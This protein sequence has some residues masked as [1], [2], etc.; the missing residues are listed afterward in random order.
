MLI[1]E[2]KDIP[3]LPYASAM[4]APNNNIFYHDRSSI[5]FT[6]HKINAIINFYIYGHSQS[7]ARDN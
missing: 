4:F 2:E 3:K 5:H 6:L 1:M 7:N